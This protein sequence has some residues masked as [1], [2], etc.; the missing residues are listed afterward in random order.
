MHQ[1]ESFDTGLVNLFVGVFVVNERWPATWRAIVGRQE[2][3][4]AG[5]WGTITLF[6][7]SVMCSNMVKTIHDEIDCI[8][9][10]K[11]TTL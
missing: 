11:E 9:S 2:N 10:A 8:F 5:R 3:R 6:R 4:Q 1:S 7:G